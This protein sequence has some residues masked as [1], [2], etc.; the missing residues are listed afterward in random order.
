MGRT[1][2]RRTVAVVSGVSLALAACSPTS[3]DRS[4]QTCT[5]TIGVMGAL[6]GDFAEF[7]A[8]PAR[9][10]E[11]AVDLANEEGNL[12]CALE[13]H[14]ENTDADPKVAPAAA[15]ALVED[16]DLVACV[17]GYF[18][19]ET[20]AAGTV[21]GRAGI[22]MLSTGEESGMRERGFETWFRLVTPVDRQATATGVYI[23]RVLEPRSV[24]I[25][26]PA[27]KQTYADDVVAHLRAALGED[28]DSAL[29]RLNP[30]G[31]G[32]FVAAREIRRLSPDVVFYAGYAP[33]PWEVLRAMRT[34]YG[35]KMPFVTDGGAIGGPQGRKPAARML[36]SCACSDVTKIEGTEA[37][38]AEYRARY[39]TTPELFAAE[40]FDGANAVIDAL[41]ELTGSESTEEV[42]AHVV[43]YLDVTDGIDG[44]VRRYAWDRG[45][46]ITDDGDVWMWEWTRRRGFRMLG[47]VAELID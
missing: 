41:R 28:V 33:E 7:G 30:E 3:S 16:E 21:F 6:E 20:S 4:R 35:L 14:A 11:I 47:S 5:W 25:V 22:A 34:S 15:R 31:T 32:V 19:G 13:S 12:A 39:D 10:V 42:R 1:N 44:I 38:L 9:G 23:R 46:L 29:V 36:L 45:E 27:T 26:R 37:F 18:S 2:L 17:C 24:A 43:D 8:P 40:G